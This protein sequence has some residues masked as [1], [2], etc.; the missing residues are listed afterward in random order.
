MTGRAPPSRAEPGRA[1]PG[2]S[3]QPRASRAAVAAG[4][5][6]GAAPPGG[7]EV[8]AGGACAAT[9]RATSSRLIQRP[10]RLLIRR[11][12]S[13]TRCELIYDSLRTAYTSI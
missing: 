10:A 6:A 12:T 5:A 2:R 1:E 9:W 11:E 4:G 3:A 8:P 7:R 13:N